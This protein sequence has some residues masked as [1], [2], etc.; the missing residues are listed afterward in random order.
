MIIAC[1]DW[2]SRNPRTVKGHVGQVLIKETETSLEA[3][4]TKEFNPRHLTAS[5]IGPEKQASG[6]ASVNDPRMWYADPRVE[7]L[8]PPHSERWE[9]KTELLKWHTQQLSW[10]RRKSNP[11]TGSSRDGHHLSAIRH[12]ERAQKTALLPAAT[13]VSTETAQRRQR[14]GLLHRSA[15]HIPYKCISY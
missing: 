8:P 1:Q 5:L 7:L 2:K 12:R 10:R 9:I 6:W 13:H 3:L 4:Y 11:R 14:R 15:F